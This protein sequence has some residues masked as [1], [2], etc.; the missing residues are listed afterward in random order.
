MSLYVVVRPGYRARISFPRLRT[1]LIKSPG[2]GEVQKPGSGSQ[3]RGS[4]HPQ[5][6]E[7][8]TGAQSAA[9]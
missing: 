4:F 5:V 3:R 7:E 9:G 2:R 6:S 1:G 8:R